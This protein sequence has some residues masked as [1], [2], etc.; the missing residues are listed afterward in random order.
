MRDKLNDAERVKIVENAKL[1]IK[2]HKDVVEYLK[3]NKRHFTDEGIDFIVKE[4]SV[5]YMPEGVYNLY[6]DF[7]EFSGRIILPIYDQYNEL[8][9]LS[10]RDWRENAYMKFF[11]ES[12]PKTRYLYGLNVAKE[13][14]IKNKRA[15]LVEGEFDV[16]YLHYRGIK[17][18]AGIMSSNLHLYQISLLCRYCKDIYIVF[19][20]DN[21]GK[22]SKDKIVNK[23]I[24][25][26]MFSMYDINIIPVILPDKM[27]PDD[28]V[29]NNGV[30]EFNNLLEKSKKDFDE[31]SDERIKEEILY[32]V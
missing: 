32:K 7:H 1:E 30:K 5:G 21:S 18:T 25:M 31:G 19:D 22:K 20:G 8:I 12:F 10:S 17:E 29:F 3:S 28:F 14:I 11:H 6:G 23:S 15:I 26:K 4:F 2:N 27:D 9:A 13:S 24:S 16:Q